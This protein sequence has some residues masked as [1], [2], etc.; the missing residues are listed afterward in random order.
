ML[1]YRSATFNRTIVE[2]KG[3]SPLADARPAKAFN[4]TI[5]ELKGVSKYSR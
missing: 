5:V 4:R 2:L 1:Q 3:H